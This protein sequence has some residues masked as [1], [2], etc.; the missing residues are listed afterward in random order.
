MSVTANRPQTNPSDRAQESAVNLQLKAVVKVVGQDTHRRKK[1]L[2][3]KDEYRAV[4]ELG[5]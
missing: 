4:I 3:R 2:A 5:F 1:P